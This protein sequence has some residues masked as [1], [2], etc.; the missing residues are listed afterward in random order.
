MAMF[1]LPFTNY[2]SPRYG[3]T[4]K[5]TLPVEYLLGSESRDAY[6]ARQIENYPAVQF[7]NQLTGPKHLLFWWNTHPS[8]YYVNSQASYLF[9]PFVPKLVTDDPK[10]IHRLLQENGVTHVMVGQRDQEAQLIS[11]SDGPFAQ[12]HLK[13]IYQKAGSIL[14]EFSS[15]PLN[16]EAI[17]YDFLSHI[18]EAAIRMPN[19]PPGKPNT[20][21]RMV[22]GI[23]TDTRYSLLGFPPSE[24]EYS[25]TLCERPL[26]QFA[27]GQAIPSCSGRGSFQIWLSRVTGER[28]QIYSR[29]LHAEQNP[30][31]V[32]WF[33]ERLDLGAF[34][35]Q[36]VK[37]LF[38]T[39]HLGGGSCVWYCW[40]DPVIL[41]QPADR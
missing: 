22:T 14:Y 29:E 33:E 31:D 20:D 32:G 40:A 25:L 39:R 6:L 11:R 24:V 23:G 1:N 17:D 9:S 2:G 36:Q 34:A 26:L 41:S 16:Q 8:V 37:I 27:V 15:Q 3:S 5:D 35:G 18:R 38:E 10:E 12:A 13:K 28:Q 7:F 19:E 4:I 21:Y 30:Q